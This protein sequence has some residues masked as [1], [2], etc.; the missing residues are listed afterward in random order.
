M[1][2]KV[3]DLNGVEWMVN[4][5]DRYI[6]DKAHGTLTMFNKDN[7]EIGYFFTEKITGFVISFNPI[8]MRED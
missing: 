7:I 1:T 4:A 5:V 3:I 6:L 8:A 2:I